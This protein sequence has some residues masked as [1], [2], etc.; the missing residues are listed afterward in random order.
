[1]GNTRRHFT[2]KT[3]GAFTS[4]W[5]SVKENAMAGIHAP[6]TVSKDEI[7]QKYFHGPSF[8]VLAGIVRVNKETSLAV[9]NTTPRPQ[10]ND[11]P[12]TLFGYSG[13]LS[14]TMRLPLHDR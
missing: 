7:Y 1:M 3:L 8:Q 2:A 11:G 10:W 13:N 5:N 9:Y 14:K 4:T 6:F 12:R